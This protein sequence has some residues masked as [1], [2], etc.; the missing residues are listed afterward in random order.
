MLHIIIIIRVMHKDIHNSAKS[1]NV[2]TY[3][4]VC[5]IC[6]CVKM[7]KNDIYIVIYYNKDHI[8]ICTFTVYSYII[9][10]KIFSY[11]MYIYNIFGE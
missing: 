6:K 9:I 4:G 3:T 1:N 11:F 10:V 5:R 8:R 7:C 2:T